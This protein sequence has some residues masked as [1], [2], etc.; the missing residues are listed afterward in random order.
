[1]DGLEMAYFYKKKVT[2]WQGFY[3][4]PDLQTAT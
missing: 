4:K 3:N 1:M 2:V